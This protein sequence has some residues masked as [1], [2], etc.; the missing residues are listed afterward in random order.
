[1]VDEG[2]LGIEWPDADDSG[3]SDEWWEEGL[4]LPF[5]EDERCMSDGTLSAGV[6]MQKDGCSKAA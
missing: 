4:R 1:M 6:S 5:S 2:A 3:S